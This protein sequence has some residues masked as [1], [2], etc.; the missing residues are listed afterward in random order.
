MLEH[1]C[2]VRGIEYCICTNKYCHMGKE[3]SVDNV[4]FVF[5]FLDPCLIS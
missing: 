4:F 1:W 3:F 2:I 5:S